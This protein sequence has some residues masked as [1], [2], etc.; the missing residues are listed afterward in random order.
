M[1]AVTSSRAAP[2]ASSPTRLAP[3]PP[4]PSWK[5][6]QAA[7]TKAPIVI[8]YIGETHRYGLDRI[9]GSML[10]NTF[11]N[12]DK[13]ERLVV[14]ERGMV[15]PQLHLADV[16]ASAQPIITEEKM[17]GTM[18]LN[19]IASEDARSIIAA[20]YLFLCVANGRQDRSSRFLVL[21]GQN[22]IDDMAQAFEYFVLNCT[23]IAWVRK[24][25]RG[26]FTMTSQ[27]A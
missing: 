13:G 5:S 12:Q 16:K 20:A 15:T 4:W 2:R 21:F 25:S 14:L 10:W 22:H 17:T 9:R 26:Y 27:K 7:E 19:S 24:R 6:H 3:A 18:E 1:S 23:S 11:N 8:A